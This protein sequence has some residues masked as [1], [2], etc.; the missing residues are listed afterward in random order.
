MADEENDEHAG[1]LHHAGVGEPEGKRAR[2]QRY[3]R[4]RW[5]GKAY[6]RVEQSA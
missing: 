4:E 5:Q 1:N 3:F 6:E 2:I